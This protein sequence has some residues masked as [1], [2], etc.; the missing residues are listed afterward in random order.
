MTDAADRARVIHA[1]MIVM[2]RHLRTWN[3]AECRQEG[4]VCPT[5]PDLVFSQ[6][7][8]RWGVRVRWYRHHIDCNAARRWE[9]IAISGR[10]VSHRQDGT[11]RNS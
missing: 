10:G 3:S 4:A 9:R 6:A 7:T 11:G 5:P 1:E 2:S 8:A